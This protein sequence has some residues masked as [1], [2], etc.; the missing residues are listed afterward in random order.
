MTAT[1][2]TEEQQLATEKLILGLKAGFK[3]FELDLKAVMI[4]ALEGRGIQTAAFGMELVA[5]NLA[6]VVPNPHG[7]DFAWDREALAK[8]S[9][10]E[11]YSL[12]ALGES[13]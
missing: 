9:T 10:V 3:V 7:P 5:E 11:V 8:L 1:Q 2:V 4:D 12:Y 6:N 13:A